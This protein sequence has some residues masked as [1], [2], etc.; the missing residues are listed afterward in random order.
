MG[1][2]LTIGALLYGAFFVQVYRYSRTHDVE[3]AE[4]IIVLGAA[5]Y[6]GE[7]SPVFKARLDHAY[8]LFKQKK[9]AMIITTGGNTAGDRYTEGEV[10]KKYLEKRGINSNLLIAEEHSLN[11][12]QNIQR[13]KEITS[14]LGMRHILLVS[15]GFHLFRATEIAASMGFH[16]SSSAVPH[17]PISRGQAFIEY[18]PKE[19]ASA[20]LYSLFD[21]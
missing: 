14:V 5:Q 10:G 18:M 20:M 19:A 1:I 17:S 16:V 4:V 6:D 12:L 3:S 7:P 15:D 21:M 13:A 2:I 11:T 9:A 8:D